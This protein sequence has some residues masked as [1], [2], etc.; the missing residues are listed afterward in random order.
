MNRLLVATGLAVGFHASLLGLAFEGSRPLLGPRPL[1]GSLAV[2]L[3]YR[4][5]AVPAGEKPLPAQKRQ[6]EPEPPRVVAKASD[7]PRQVAVAASAA[8]VRAEL[9][10][11][12]FEATSPE[13]GEASGQEVVEE[14]PVAGPEVSS[15]LV[16]AE[17]V[18]ASNPSPRYPRLA[19]QRGWQGVVVL[20]VFV[21]A[22]GRAG[23]VRVG[24]SCGHG[25][26]D[27][28]ALDAVREWR[29]APGQE[30]GRPV[31]MWVRVPVRFELREGE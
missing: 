9:P 13:S 30:A 6:P 15:G 29:F 17:P 11:A 20:E 10:A 1:P 23:E 8:E 4:E 2:S 31:A 27:R 26:L 18:Y 24:E 25:L 16:R 22:G 21:D 7:R 5:P 19:R 12:P 14:A 3:T 28:A